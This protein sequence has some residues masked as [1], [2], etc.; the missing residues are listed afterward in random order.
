MRLCFCN[1]PVFGTDKK[2]RIGYCK[3]H[4]YMR[5]DLDKRSI[6]AKALDKA[7]GGKSAT[8]YTKTKVRSLLDTDENKFLQNKASEDFEKLQ[9]F[10]NHVASEISKNPYCCECGSFIHEKYYRASSAHVL[11]KRKEYGFPSVSTN[12]INFLALGA[13]CG[14]HHKYDTSWEDAAKMKVFPKAIEIFIELYPQIDKSEL[15]NIPE[16]FLK[17]IYEQGENQFYTKG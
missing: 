1:S 12:F 13:T 6:I 8:A 15:K 5:T 4:Q 2:T 16:V 17:C 7:K 11:P 3:A 10:Y 9:K 14:C